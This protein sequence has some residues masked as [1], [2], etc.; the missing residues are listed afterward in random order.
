M[1]LEKLD[2]LDSS[3]LFQQLDFKYSCWQSIIFT[4][5]NHFDMSPEEFRGSL[6]LRYGGT[7][8]NMPSFCDGDGDIFD[9]DHACVYA[10]HNELRNLNCT[11]LE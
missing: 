3:I 2:Q 4:L 8:C 6:A 7:P 10:R 9:V 11:L 1:L 5:E